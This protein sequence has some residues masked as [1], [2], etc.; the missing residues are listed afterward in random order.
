M[1]RLLDCIDLDELVFVME[2]H[3]LGVVKKFFEPVEPTDASSKGKIT[4]Y[5]VL[6]V[7][8]ETFKP[9]IKHRV[10]KLGTEDLDNVS[11]QMGDEFRKIVGN[12]ISKG[13]AFGAYENGSLASFA[14]VPQVIEDFFN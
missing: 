2:P 9:L 8:A 11:K 6:R 4:T 13:I 12:A 10:K 1:P 3:H 7:D 14:T 5:L